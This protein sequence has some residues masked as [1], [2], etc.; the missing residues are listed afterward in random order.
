MCEGCTD[1][2]GPWSIWHSTE[3]LEPFRIRDIYDICV[4]V[5][6]TTEAPFVIFK[7]I[8]RSDSA[9]NVQQFTSTLPGPSRTFNEEQSGSSVLTPGLVRAG[10]V[11]MAV[12]AAEE[13]QISSNRLVPVPHQSDAQMLAHGCQTGEVARGESI[14]HFSIEAIKSLAVKSGKKIQ[15][16]LGIMI[17]AVGPG[18]TQITT[19]TPHIRAS[20][21]S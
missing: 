17:F 18:H 6:R 9:T 2:I 5:G 3:L 15:A 20:V 7:R 13:K 11:A 19:G 21:S 10:Q 12:I 4:T 1:L 14:K 8:T 16:C